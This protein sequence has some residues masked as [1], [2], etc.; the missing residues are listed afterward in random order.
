MNLRKPTI[1]RIV[2]ISTIVS[3]CVAFIIARFSKS[4]DADKYKFPIMSRETWEALGTPPE[5]VEE[6]EDTD[7]EE[8]A[9]PSE[10]VLEGYTMF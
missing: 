4:V 2:I 6:G 3:V 7:E 8:I 1:L 5:T 9:S 10:E